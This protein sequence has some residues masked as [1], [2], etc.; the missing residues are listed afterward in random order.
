MFFFLFAETNKN[1]EKGLDKGCCSAH[2]Q[3]CP[4]HT[5][6]AIHRKR[7]DVFNLELYTVQCNIMHDR[8]FLRFMPDVCK[9]NFLLDLVHSIRLILYVCVCFL[10][11]KFSISF[12][13][14]KEKFELKGDVSRPQQERATCPH[15]K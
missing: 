9:R 1:N 11:Q 5:F 3:V 4:G 13:L 6:Q 8:Y 12:I 15:R 7:Y 2:Q 14:V 10:Y